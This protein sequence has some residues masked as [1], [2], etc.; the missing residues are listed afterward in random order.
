MQEPTPAKLVVIGGALAGQ[1]FRLAERK[2][3]FGRESSNDIGVPDATLSRLHC[4]FERGE[5]GWTVRDAGS[6]NGTFVNGSRIQTH[7]LAGGDRISAGECLLLYVPDT[8]VA[9]AAVAFDDGE[10]PPLTARLAPSDAAYLS[11]PDATNE[12]LQPREQGLKAL[13]AISTAIHAERDENQLNRQL[14]ALLIDA[15]HAHEAALVRVVSGHGLDMQAVHPASPAERVHIN[16]AVVERAIREGVGILCTAAPGAGAPRVCSILAVPLLVADQ[17]RAA[18]YLTTRPGLT[19]NE[20]HLQLATAVARIAAVAVANIR[21]VAA[22]ECETDRLQANLHLTGR[23]IGQSPA[24]DLVSGRI[25]KVARVDTT[26]LITGETGTGKELAARAIHL[27]SARARRPFVAINCAAL[28]E[29]L[30]ESELFGHER[31]AFTGAVVQKKGRLELA[32]GGTVFLDEVGELAIGLQSKLLRVLQQREFERVGGTQPIRVDVRILSATNR[33]LPAAVASGGFRQDLFY[34][35]NVVSLHVPALRERREDIAV[36]ARHFFSIYAPKSGRRLTGISPPALRRL[37][38]YDWPGN[39]RE[40]ENAIERAC[41]LGSSDE[42]L[43]EDLPETIIDSAPATASGTIAGLHA[44]VV[45]AKREAIITAYRQSGGSYTQAAT[46]LGVHPN[47]L[48]RLIR[49]LR[50]KAALQD[51]EA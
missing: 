25:T 43:E 9:D 30:L 15:L 37:R 32:D 11:S 42:I 26:V 18:I 3:T 45:E 44:F 28:T 19:F 2:V 21:H 4:V 29:P 12:R 35:L 51:S 24:M 22:L 10:P 46:L 38:D 48:H 17:T 39:V 13:L 5:A 27:R 16:A 23:L 41:V 50:I 36:L 33:D 34:R 40:L 14:L 47:Y 20:D 49:N 31:G 1:V 8:A 7:L 6:S